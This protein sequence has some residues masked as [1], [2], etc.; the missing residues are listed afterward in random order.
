MD[1]GFPLA[2]TLSIEARNTDCGIASS[3]SSDPSSEMS[4]IL[5]YF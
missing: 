3:F 2:T 1:V 4:P 5:I